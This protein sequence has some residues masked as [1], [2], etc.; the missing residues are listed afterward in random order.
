MT[1]RVW[2]SFGYTFLLEAPL[3]KTHLAWF[4]PLYFT[5][6]LEV[7]APVMVSVETGRGVLRSSGTTEQKVSTFWAGRRAMQ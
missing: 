4:A 2:L 1:L 5:F 6:D 3:R 7:F